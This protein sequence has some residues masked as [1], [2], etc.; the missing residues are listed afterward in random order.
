[1]WCGLL[2]DFLIGPH[3]LP[4]HL[5][6]DAYLDFLVNTLPQLLEVS[7][8]VCQSM[9]YMHD[10]APVYFSIKVRNHLNDAYPGRRIGCGSPVV[11]L[12]RSPDLNPLD[13]FVWG[14]L[15]TLVYET[16]VETEADLLPCIQAA[17][18]DI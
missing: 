1:V 12:A 4:N 11:W 8:Q 10:E 3:V 2:D 7:L 18:D 9:W 14:Y 13:F 17:C 5:M 6:G 16:T 15:K